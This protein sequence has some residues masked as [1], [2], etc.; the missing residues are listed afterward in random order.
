MQMRQCKVAG[1]VQ[2][3]EGEGEWMVYNQVNID[4]IHSM[5]IIASI[6]C[7]IYGAY[8]TLKI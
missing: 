5:Y 7:N 1:M 4:G 6:T 3:G 2:E 8:F